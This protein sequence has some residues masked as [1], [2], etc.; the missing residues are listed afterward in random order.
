VDRLDIGG[1]GEWTF[2]SPV[3]RLGVDIGGWGEWTFVSPVDRLGVD[4]GVGGN[5]HSSR[6]LTGWEWT[7]VSPVDRLGVDI[8]LARGPVGH[9]WL[10][11]WTS[12]SPVNRLGF[13]GM[14]IGIVVLCVA[15]CQCVKPPEPGSLHKLAVLSYG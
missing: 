1:W 3:D 7:F 11:E 8:R 5:G 12:V 15:T 10:G 4:I 6:P 14:D 9:W 2:V 13:G